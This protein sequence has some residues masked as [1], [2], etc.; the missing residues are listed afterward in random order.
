MIQQMISLRKLIY[1]HQFNVFYVKSFVLMNLIVGVI[2]MVVVL[3]VLY[4]PVLIMHL[5]KMVFF[6]IQHVVMVIMVLVLCVGKNV[7]M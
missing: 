3:V 4:I 1:H 7:I 6:A 5:N 2:R